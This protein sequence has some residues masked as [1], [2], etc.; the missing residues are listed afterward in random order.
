MP[1]SRPGSNW[2]P[3]T[4]QLGNPQQLEVAFR[5][6]LNKIY[7]LQQQIAALQ[8]AQPA[9]AAATAPSGPPPGSGPADSM[10]LG[11]RVGP[12]DTTN[13]ANGATLKFNKA[14]GNFQF[15]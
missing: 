10:L 3:T 14:A 4:N 1:P 6:A 13:L 9:A 15:S 8:A 11:L 2:Y 7:E 5:Q 12:A